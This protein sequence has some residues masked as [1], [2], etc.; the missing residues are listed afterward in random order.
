MKNKVHNLFALVMLFAFCNMMLVKD[1][2]HHDC[3]LCS[4]CVSEGIDPESVPLV[5]SQADYCPICH[6]TIV[7]QQAQISHVTI[8]APQKYVLLRSFY[9]ESIFTIASEE[10]SSRGPPAC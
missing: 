1:F 8:E 7:P 4:S 5:L 10:P 6:F 3:A 9:V 2:H